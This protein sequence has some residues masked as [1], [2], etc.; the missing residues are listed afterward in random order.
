MPKIELSTEINSSIEICFDLS[1][2]IDLHQ[3]ST[4]NTSEKAISGITNGLIDLNEHVT[5]EANHFGVR[6]QLTSKITAYQR[7]YHFVDE[8][9][10][11]IFKS[12]HHSHEFKEINGKVIMTDVFNFSSPYGIFGRIFNLLILKAY[13]KNL[14]THRNEV[15]KNY[16]ETEKWKL[17]LDEKQYL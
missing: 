15:I 6:Q 8:Q 2:S 9:V 16:A 4:A 1:R 12:I 10:K 17:V 11:G 13:L 5:W 14:L 7:P 3:I